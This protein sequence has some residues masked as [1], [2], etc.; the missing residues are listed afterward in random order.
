VSQKTTVIYDLG[1]SSV[2]NLFQKVSR[3]CNAVTDW[4]THR[5]TG[6]KNKANKA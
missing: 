5:Q 6:G 3:D 2:S 1:N 4:L